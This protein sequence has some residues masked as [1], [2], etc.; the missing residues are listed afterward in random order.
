M[1]DQN[2]RL[3]E[4]INDAHA[5]L[6]D[7][8][9][10]SKH[11]TTE[12][13]AIRSSLQKTMD[14]LRNDLHEMRKNLQV[15]QDR[16]SHRESEVGVL[17]A[18]NIRMK[19]GG[20]SEALAILKRELSDQL[21]QAKRLESELR[22]LRKT[23]KKVEVVEEQ[24]KAL[25]NKLQFM[26]EVEAELRNLQIQKQILEDERRSWT[27]ILQTEDQRAEFESP[28]AVVRA[29]VQA[30]IENASLVDKI[31][32]IKSE[33]AEK[34]EMIKNLE[35]EK[36]NLQK[37]VEKL[38]SN[39][40][41]GTGA[42]SRAKT[43]LDRQRVLAI[44]EVEYLRAQLKTFD[45]EETTMNP[46]ENRFDAQKSEHISQL[47]GLLSEHREELHKLHEELS[48][49][50]TAVV[51]DSHAPRGTK[52]PLSPADSDA[53]SERFAVLVRKNRIL[54]DS[55]SKSGNL[56]STRTRRHKISSIS[57]TSTISN[58]YP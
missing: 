55:L 58:P 17:E 31:G 37:E 28:E 36:T 10:Q 46:E 41:I 49:H 52:R 39:G 18:E 4:D 45:V 3:Q 7:Q 42:D 48:K 26:R 24:K 50:E 54:Q 29:L 21:A 40:G 20:D 25:E 13:E 19:T 23:Q 47:E 30:R 5:Q 27:S 51:G 6:S 44:K 16:L 1:E 53:E 2:L 35:E 15:A 56:A 9:R 34:I 57:S 11:Q 43:R 14:D 12:F 22:P 38:R 8:E 32:T 33:V